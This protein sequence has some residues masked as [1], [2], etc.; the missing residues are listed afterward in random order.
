MD[1][2]VHPL[3]GLFPS[4]VA[5]AAEDARL[6]GEAAARAGVTKMC[7]FSVHPEC[8]HEPTVDQCRE[9]N[10]Y[11]LSL[12]DA[13]PDLFLPFCYV[14]PMYPDE[15]VA[16]IDRRIQADRMC[17]I[18]LWVA[19]RGTDPGLDP[20]LTR[21]AELGVPVLQHAWDKTTGN[22]PGECFPSDV[23]DMARRHPRTSIFMAHLNGCGLRGV[24]H[25]ADHPNVLV[26]TSG[27]DP[28]SGMVE[29]AVEAL[30]PKRVVYA[31]DLPVRLLGQ[32]LGKVLGA[33]LPEETR[34][35]ILWNN[36]ARL[37]PE[38]AGVKPLEGSAA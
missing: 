9:A 3:A 11:V 16:E 33:D 38:W 18:K 31:S 4:G 6:I 35:D 23:A 32:C 8:P 25:V 12:R 36:A 2:H 20:I 37:M 22:L 1:V 13:A 19:R 26:D 30:G 24:A 34:R 15:A 27:G 5:S 29:A 17:G 21:A 10:D 7:L 28:E 14:S